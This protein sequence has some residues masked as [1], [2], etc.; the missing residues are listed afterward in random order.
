MC[1]VVEGPASS[2]G[3]LVGVTS[4]AVDVNASCAVLRPTNSCAIAAAVA[5][6]RV[7]FVFFSP[8]W[9]Q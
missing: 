7:F 3:V 8:A 9:T 2:A 5:Q 6:T 4:A 1:A